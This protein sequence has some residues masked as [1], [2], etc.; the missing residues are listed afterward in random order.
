MCA[1]RFALRPSLVGCACAPA[2]LIGI[3]AADRGQVPTDGR[4]PL[5]HH[6]QGRPTADGQLRLALRQLARSSLGVECAVEPLAE[7]DDPGVAARTRSGPE[8]C[9]QRIGALGPRRGFPVERLELRALMIAIR[10]RAAC[11]ARG[12]EQLARRLG[13]R[14]DREGGVAQPRV[15]FALRGGRRLRRRGNLPL[16]PLELRASGGQ[17]GP[18]RPGQLRSSAS[19]RQL[20]ARLGDLPWTGIRAQTGASKE[21]GAFAALRA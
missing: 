13:R 15:P 2:E 11:H 7:S 9:E 10:G 14:I 17:S 3:R 8:G 4:L 16:A 5:F 12:A 18:G 1:C 6:L 21:V 20:V 19:N